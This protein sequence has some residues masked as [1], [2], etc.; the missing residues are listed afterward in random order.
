MRGLTTLGEVGDDE[1]GAILSRARLH[2]AARDRGETSPATLRGR[3]VTL[4]FF[5]PSTRTRLSFDVAARRLGAEVIDFDPSGSST[6]KGESLADTA[7]TL[8]AMGTDVFVLRHGLADGPDFV[9][10]RT[11]VPVVS[12]GAGRREH[13]TQTLI[14]ALTLTD[15]FEELRGLRMG[16]VG[17][18]ANSRVARGHLQLFPR[19]GVEVTLIGPSTLL[20]EANPWGVRMSHDLDAELGELD[21][22]YLLRVQTERGAG[23]AIPSVA[24]Y[25][26][27]FGLGRDRLSS[28]KPGTVVMHPGPLNRGVEVDDVVADGERSLVLDQVANGVPLRMAV[29]EH[30][31][32]A[33]W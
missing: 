18:V 19:L 30:V 5:E 3:L 26:R 8:A 22:V 2:R 29:L 4:A 15:R 10:R 21:V 17:D 28:L 12:A 27:R 16:I 7:A 33:G 20:P 1:V 9:R 23:S 24:G 14:D 13:P 32:E 6:E 11:G 25:A 31:L